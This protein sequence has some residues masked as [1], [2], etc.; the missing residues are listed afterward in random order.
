MITPAE[1]ITR[2][3]KPDLM[4]YKPVAFTGLPI[5]EASRRFLVEAGLPQQAGLELEFDLPPDELFT[6]A[7]AFEQ[8]L[9][10][11]FNR[12]RP[13]G[14]DAATAICLDESDGWRLY[15]VDVDGALPIRF[16]NSGVPQLAEFLL[17]FREGAGVRLP[18]LASEEELEASA[19][20][21][22]REFGRIDPSVF[23]DPENWWPLI[24][25]QRRDGLL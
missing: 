11:F 19:Q 24:I 23:S 12:Y 20:A 22:E 2:W 14:L 16:V 5:P 9:P 15:A 17:V 7:E 4:P 10:A 21:L 1:F 25:M 6:L 3:G 13:I 8:D 18:E